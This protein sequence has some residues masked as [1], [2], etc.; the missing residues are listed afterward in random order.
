MTRLVSHAFTLAIVLGA[1]FQARLTAYSAQQYP[2]LVASGE[3]TTV[4]LLA[5]DLPTVAAHP[6]LPFGTQV[7][8]EG[9]GVFTVRDRGR[10]GADHLDVLVERTVEA[11]ALT[12][13]RWACVVEGEG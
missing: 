13:W 12:G 2:G 4:E 9:L 7:W 8:V 1:C 3:A 11:W 10:L 5:A 6:W